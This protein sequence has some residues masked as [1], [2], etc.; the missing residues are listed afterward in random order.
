M[1]KFK[2][3][4]MALIIGLFITSLGCINSPTSY[5]TKN[6]PAT[7]PTTIRTASTVTTPISNANHSAVNNTV[8]T[9]TQNIVP[10]FEIQMSDG[11]A[12]SFPVSLTEN[13]PV[14]LMF[15]TPH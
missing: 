8:G 14:F 4:Y 5:S 2:H 11:V 7:I 13:N 9:E 10:E 1:K 6:A 12:R 3:I 15:F